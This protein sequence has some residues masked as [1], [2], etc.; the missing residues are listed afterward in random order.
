M[1]L[2]NSPSI[3]PELLRIFQNMSP[4]LGMYYSIN[5]LVFLNTAIVL[6]IIGD[7][8][9]SIFTKVPDFDRKIQ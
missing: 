3:T 9:P 6:S 8:K 7:F 4:L 1:T 5:L 2:E